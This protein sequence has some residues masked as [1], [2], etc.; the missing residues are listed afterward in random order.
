MVKQTYVLGSSCESRECW[1]DI[2]IVRDGSGPG[3]YKIVKKQLRMIQCP[4]LDTAQSSALGQKQLRFICI[5]GDQGPDQAS[6]RKI[7]AR[8]FAECL[9]V[10]V[11]A[12]PCL[13]HQQSLA[14]GRVLAR[15]E[16]CCTAFGFGIPYYQCL[17]KLTHVW[18][19]DT[20]LVC[21]VAR[22]RFL[23]SQPADADHAKNKC[24]QCCASRW[25][26]V[27]NVEKYFLDFSSEH[28]CKHILS[29]AYF[30]NM[31]DEVQPSLAIQDVAG[32]PRQNLRS[33]TDE[34][35]LDAM[36]AHKQKQTRWKRDVQAGT[37]TCE[38]WLMMRI[39]HMALGPLAHF[40]HVLQPKKGTPDTPLI[41]L[42]CGG[43]SDQIMR[44]F[45]AVL[46]DPDQVWNQELAF[47]DRITPAQLYGTL[48][49]LVGVGAAEYDSRVHSLISDLPVQLLWLAH[50]EPRTYCR[51][52][53]RVCKLVMEMNP[54]ELDVTTVKL[55]TLMLGSFRDG[56][57]NGKISVEDHVLLEEWRQRVRESSQ[58]V[59]SA[60]SV[61]SHITKL[62]HAIDQPLLASRFTQK[63]CIL[64][65]GN[66]TPAVLALANEV[67]TTYSTTQY[68]GI[69]AYHDRW[70][71]LT[72]THHPMELVP[73]CDAPQASQAGVPECGSAD[74]PLRV[75]GLLRPTALP[76]GVS[77]AGLEASAPAAL[78]WS[79][80]WCLDVAVKC[81]WITKG[82]ALE[83]PAAG[84]VAYL[85]V[86]KLRNLG[87]WQQLDISCDDDG[88]LVGRISIPFAFTSSAFAIAT[89]WQSLQDRKRPVR[90]VI[91]SASLDWTSPLQ[92]VL[93][94]GARPVFVSDV[95]A[96]D[97]KKPKKQSKRKPCKPT[98]Q[99]KRQ[100]QDQPR[101]AD[102]QAEAEEHVYDPGDPAELE[103][104]D[105][106]DDADVLLQDV[107][108]ADVGEEG[109]EMV[110]ALAEALGVVDVP[111]VEDLP[112]AAPDHDDCMDP[113][114]HVDTAEAKA[115]WID[116]VR[117]SLQALE[118][119]QQA[120]D[121]VVFN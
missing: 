3:C 9:R 82:A 78:R 34:I 11:V 27:H 115:T 97:Q 99:T 55:K 23:E 63:Q 56:A 120:L 103:E 17:V 70:L 13:A 48:V 80:A 43:K 38:F 75:C 92:A 45:E 7:V 10:I 49:T 29:D 58:V 76:P 21:K 53:Q 6:F 95:K 61:I 85:C 116:A 90:R 62:A 22:V 19:A 44:D 84:D 66:D 15:M 98:P 79:A 113:T 86:S 8:Q 112:A 108:D 100:K 2:Q 72:G 71:D 40:L 41:S 25:G 47:L 65:H 117:T 31:S 35:N 121:V 50:C 14:C 96:S 93:K 30:Q 73:L 42:V 88:I 33:P 91:C 74:I 28:V 94:G 87:K 60:N 1:P 64:S 69:L 67:A 4:A 59:E 109:L 18:R 89:A 12:L 102:E 107:F 110:A 54:K 106:P 104:S 16:T 68:Q 119:W 20:A 32:P 26:S 51:E 101:T 77:R 46:T 81:I 118:C 111:N 5:N 37:E 57:E 83:Y 52:R 24:P 36:N 114:M 39:S 105:K